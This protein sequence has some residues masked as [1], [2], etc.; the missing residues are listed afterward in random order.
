MVKYILVAFWSLLYCLSMW[1]LGNL[2]TS[3]VYCSAPLYTWL[4]T[5]RQLL[6]LTHTYST[7]IHNNLLSFFPSVLS[8]DVLYW[9]FSYPFILISVWESSFHF[10]E[11]ISFDASVDSIGS[12]VYVLHLGILLQLGVGLNSK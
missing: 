12:V 1:R 7:A 9:W 3:V 4:Y 8:R 6:R 11:L 2:K 5:P 10:T